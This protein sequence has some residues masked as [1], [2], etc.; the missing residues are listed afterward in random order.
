MIPVAPQPEPDNFDK[1]VRQPG[2][3]WLDKNGID[4][5]NAPPEPGKLPAYWQK[6]NEQLWEAYSGVCAYLAIYFEWVLGASS[7]DHFIPKS[8][9]AGDTYEWSNYRLACLGPN[10]SKNKF[11]DLL[12]PFEIKPDTFLLN[13]ASGAIKPNP[14]LD[15]PLMDIAST[16]IVRL[17]LDSEQHRKMRRNA[18]NRYLRKKDE[19]SLKEL[20]PFVWHEAQRQGLL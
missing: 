19:E 3:A 17:N 2:L 11:T 4:P 18:F 16:T 14:E 9:L 7:T 15:G 13:L 20:S 12:D 5:R 8:S 10:R 1:E 6:T